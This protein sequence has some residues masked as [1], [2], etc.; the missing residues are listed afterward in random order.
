MKVAFFAFLVFRLRVV[1]VTFIADRQ[2]RLEQERLST[3]KA[4]HSL[5]E[6]DLNV[7]FVSEH[8]SYIGT[9]RP[10]GAF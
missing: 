7:Q 1:L 10:R 5:I 9:A 4:P 6:A 2:A 8:G 3:R